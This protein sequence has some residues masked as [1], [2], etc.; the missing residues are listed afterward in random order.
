MP[1]NCI[2]PNNIGDFLPIFIAA[3]ATV[4]LKTGAYI[5]T[6]RPFGPG[7]NKELK[8]GELM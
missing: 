7:N 5:F 8:S 6:S 1:I 3:L 2:R 4:I